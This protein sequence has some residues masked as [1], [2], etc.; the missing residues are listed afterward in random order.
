MRFKLLKP[1]TFEDEQKI[2]RQY[3]LNQLSFCIV[4]GPVC[5]AFLFE[6]RLL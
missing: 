1:N 4:K 3:L 6:K 2:Y 5:G